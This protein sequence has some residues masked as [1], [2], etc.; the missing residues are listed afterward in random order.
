MPITSMSAEKKLQVYNDDSQLIIQ[1][2]EDLSMDCLVNV[3]GR[4]GLESL[5]L[6]VPFVCKSWYNATLSPLC[7]Q[8]LDFSTISFFGSFEPR[9]EKRIRAELQVNGKI[10]LNAFVKFLLLRRGG[11]ATRIVFPRC[12]K[13]EALVLAA[14]VCP[15]LKTLGLP[16]FVELDH[17]QHGKITTV[18][19]LIRKW[20]DLDSLIMENSWEMI[21]ILEQI[22]IHCKNVVSLS[23]KGTYIDGSEALAIVTHMPNIN[24]LFLRQCDFKG[25]NLLMILKGCNRL[26]SFDMSYC[27]VNSRG[28]DEILEL[29]SRIG[30]V[31]YLSNKNNHF[32]LESMEWKV[33]LL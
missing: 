25:A 12:C 1:Q 2:W 33:D 16:I 19:H 5:V 14:N 11:F 22:G 8:N 21:A 3:F 29:A 9:F 26:S 7:W 10:N 15:A 24:S 32:Y 30:M 6:D 28:G 13:H 18:K 4:L 27:N 17:D 20:K 23:I 31:K